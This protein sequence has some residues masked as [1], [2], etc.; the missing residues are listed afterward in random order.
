MKVRMIKRQVKKHADMLAENKVQAE[1]IV[2]LR[3]KLCANQSS[4]DV[5]RLWAESMKGERG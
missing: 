4:I 5:L 1:S 2:S 3:S